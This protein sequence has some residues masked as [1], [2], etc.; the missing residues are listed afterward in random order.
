M[1]R[2]IVILS[3][4]L[5]VWAVSP[6]AA[7]DTVAGESSDHTI[8]I[9]EE[10]REYIVH[11]PANYDDS[12]PVPLVIMLH[13]GGGGS[14]EF[15]A[16]SGMNRVA[17]SAGFL[18]VYPESSNGVWNF[19]SREGRADDLAF[20][21]ALLEQVQTDYAVNPAQIY[22]V[23]YSNGGLMALRMRCS[24]S[25]QQAG[26]G[27]MNATMTYA[28]AEF[29]LDAPPL[30]TILALGMSDPAFPWEGYAAAGEDDSLISTFS[31]SQT[32]GFFS[33][34]NHCVTQPPSIEEITADGSETRILQQ[35][36]ELCDRS[37]YFHMLGLVNFGN[38]YP[39]Q[40]TMLIDDQ[41][42]S[43]QGAIWAF[44]SQHVR[45]E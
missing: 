21:D 18:A 6:I 1:K 17:D 19:L 44:L 22:A 26:V 33:T 34:L 29:C 27:V 14:A 3:L 9:G 10:S 12:T 37:A 39:S 23:G 41:T 45:T 7:Q 32:I 8:T 24:M 4:I 25:D 20:M 40:P 31:S 36:F 5:C 13:G 16:F 15:N 43:V 30:P 28:L 2:S 42:V 38:N 11:T 35:R